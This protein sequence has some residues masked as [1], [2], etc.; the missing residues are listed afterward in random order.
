MN[1]RVFR[2]LAAAAFTAIAMGTAAA[3]TTYFS[4]DFNSFADSAT[5][6][7]G[8][9][10]S[11]TA[12]GLPTQFGIIRSDGNGGKALTIYGGEQF[13]GAASGAFAALADRIASGQG[14]LRMTGLYRTQPAFD[15]TPW[16]QT[17]QIQFQNTIGFFTYNG[18]TVSTN[19]PSWTPFTLDLDIANLDPGQLGQVQAN[20]FLPGFNPGEFQVDDL[21]IQ[22]VPEPST[23]TMVAIAVLSLG[24]GMAR[25]RRR[26]SCQAVVVS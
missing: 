26:T 8:G 9:S 21:T 18:I 15:S 20:F 7:N 13:N 3:Q 23:W 16:N 22:T 5:T 10:N 2:A 12:Y 17:A 11:L 6:V 1:R 25:R 24:G 14:L 4:S 19:T